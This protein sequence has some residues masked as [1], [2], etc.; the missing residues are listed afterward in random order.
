M[1]AGRFLDEAGLKELWAKCK[2]WFGH[3]LS[4]G[5]V[6]SD[7]V[8]VKLAS[9]SGTYASSKATLPAATAT[10]AGVMSAADKARLDGMADGANK[11]VVD[12]AL[13]DT[14]TNP[15]QNKAVQAALAGK[16][17]TLTSAQQSAAD[18]GITAAKVKK[19]DDM[20]AVGGE[21]N[22]I[23]TVKV[24]GTALTPDA[25][26]AV[27]V[28]VPAAANDATITVMAFDGTKTTFTVDQ[29]NAKTVGKAMS[30]DQLA[31]ANS[32]VTAAKVKTYDGY[33]SQIA[34]KQATL[35]TAQ[36]NAV[37]SGVT[38]ADA[39]KLH[40]TG[41]NALQTGADVDNK[42][43]TA[44]VGAAMFQGTI[45]KQADIANGYKKGYYWVVA[46]AG[47]Y[48]GQACEVGDMV[49]A[50][51]DATSSTALTNGDFSVVQSNIVA[52]TTAEVDAVC[53]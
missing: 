53:A 21:P 9:T 5:D 29:A 42:I 38:S 13:S 15:V 1:A 19:Y 43:A 22:T 24:N 14:S 23:E 48:V 30:D 39:T 46:T 50:V 20:A 51:K 45:E 41:N 8:D 44:Q 40:A 49:F 31:A 27:D 11:T 37:N 32:G 3:A 28:T 34:G 12:E 47:T 17:A 52:M 10:K 4:L 26:K 36:L 35:T 7:T 6:G 18:S 33:A 2:A 16:Q 25:S